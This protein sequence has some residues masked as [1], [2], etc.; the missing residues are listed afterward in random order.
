[1]ITKDIGMVY[2]G[3]GPDSKVLLTKGRKAAEKYKLTYGDTVPVSQL[4]K[5]LAAIMQE[6]VLVFL[7]FLF[8]FFYCCSCPHAH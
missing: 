2:S 8:L 1:M 6:Y 4:V 5:T 3:M 7:F